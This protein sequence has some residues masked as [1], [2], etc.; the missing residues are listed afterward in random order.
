M[1]GG[2][3]RN[4]A[5]LYDRNLEGHVHTTMTSL[6]HGMMWWNFRLGILATVVVTTYPMIVVTICR[7][8]VRG[9]LIHVLTSGLLM[10]QPLEEEHLHVSDV[11]FDPLSDM[12]VILYPYLDAETVQTPLA[13]ETSYLVVSAPSLTYLLGVRLTLVVLCYL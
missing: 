1:T 10:V 8:S 11:L 7:T 4:V 12:N 3:F 13:K 5:I 2:V 9:V 6:A